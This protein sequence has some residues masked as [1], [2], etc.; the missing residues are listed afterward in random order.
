MS[1]LPY[2]TSVATAAAQDLIGPIIVRQRNIGGFVADVTIKEE[3]HDELVV[4]EN[5]VE[6]GAAITDH[7]FK[8]PA[9]LT[10]DIGYSNSSIQSE[11]NPNYVQ[12]MYQQFI[13]LQ[14]SRVPFDVITGKRLYSSMLITMLQTTT[15]EETENSLL[16][17]VAMKEVILVNT[18]AVSVP[19]NSN[20][21]NPQ[22]NG[23]TTSQGTNQLQPGTAFQYSNAPYSAGFNGI[24]GN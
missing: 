11:G 23:A 21:T 1:L 9:V 24:V 12:N 17:T 19:P 5:P 16:L 22:N 18:Q 3:H 14:A 2:G 20:M 8:K 4:T 15:T 7:A 6:Q 10:V 13:S